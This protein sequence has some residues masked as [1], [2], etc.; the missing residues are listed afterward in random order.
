M[1]TSQ[2]SNPAFCSRCPADFRSTWLA[3]CTAPQPRAGKAVRPPTETSVTPQ[4]LEFLAAKCVGALGGNK[5]EPQMSDAAI[6][7]VPKPLALHL[8]VQ[9]V[10]VRIVN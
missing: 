1:L 3:S 2:I 10:R 4:D 5:I 6:S 7:R 9:I 8:G